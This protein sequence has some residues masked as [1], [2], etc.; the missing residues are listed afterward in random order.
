MADSE[1]TYPRMA[2]QDRHRFAT[3]TLAGR[4]GTGFGCVRRPASA[5][6]S[7]HAHANSKST[8]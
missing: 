3:R 4:T 6:A 2:G 8:T 1:I 5:L 7:P